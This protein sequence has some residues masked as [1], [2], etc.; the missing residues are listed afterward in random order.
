V[1]FVREGSLGGKAVSGCEVAFREGPRK[2]ALQLWE[3]DETFIGVQLG[4]LENVALKKKSP[5]FHFS[6]ASHPFSCG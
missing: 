5:S 4:G 3:Y 2:G 1:N 6:G